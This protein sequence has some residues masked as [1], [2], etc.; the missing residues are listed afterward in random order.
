MNNNQN[1]EIDVPTFLKRETIEKQRIEQ[2]RMMMERQKEAM[3]ENARRNSTGKKRKKR[4]AEIRKKLVSTAFVAG[5]S[6]AIG[7]LSVHGYQLKSGA[8]ILANELYKYTVGYDI[9]P[10]R[11][12]IL[13]G[14]EISV[15]SAIADVIN[16]ARYY[17][18]MSDDELYVATSVLYG[19][20]N[21]KKH[22]GEISREQQT[23]V[24]YKAYHESK[25]EEYT[26]DSGGM[27]K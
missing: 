4:K 17:G 5:A 16:D 23:A 3:Y 27:S 6:F 20:D 21:A 26:K 19:S 7:I 18:D 13:N 10:G 22:I 2:E 12:A 14:K 15:D 8:D 9:R 25:L 24:K 11:F 1:R